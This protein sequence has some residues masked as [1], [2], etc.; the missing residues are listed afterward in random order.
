MNHSTSKRSAKALPQVE[1][2]VL[3][4]GITKKIVACTANKDFQIGNSQVKAGEKFFLVASE[5]RENRY[6]VV[7]FNSLRAQYQCSCGANCKSHEHI[8]TTQQYVLK[9]V[10]HPK[11]EKQVAKVAPQVEQEQHDGSRPLTAAEWK[12]I[13]KR[14]KVRQKAWQD[15]YRAEAEKLKQVS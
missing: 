14:D 9:N 13:H 7:H 10:V 15:E 4:E 11:A 8:T 5:R 2:T 1:S 3:I 6:Y 12:E